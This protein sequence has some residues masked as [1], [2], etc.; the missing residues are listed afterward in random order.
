MNMADASQIVVRDY[1]P[2]RE[3]GVVALVCRYYR[4]REAAQ[5][6]HFRRFFDHPFQENE[7]LRFVALEGDRVVG[8]MTYFFWPYEYRGSRLRSFQTGN[9]LVDDSCR[10]KG[11]F[12]RLLCRFDEVRQQRGI[13]LIVGFPVE[14]SRP[15][16][17]GAGWKVVADLAWYVRIVSPLSVVLSAGPDRVY[18]SLDR[19]PRPIE[20]APR[21]DSVVLSRDADFLAWRRGVAKGD[22]YA[23]FHHEDSGHRLRLDLRLKRRRVRVFGTG[24]T[25][26]AREMM[27][28]GVHSSSRDPAFVEAGLNRL[29]TTMRR[30]RIAALLSIALNEQSN[31]T[32]VLEGV[33]RSGFRRIKKTYCFM[34]R[35]YADEDELARPE[36]WNVFRGDADTW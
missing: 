29:A 26:P 31:E 3:D 6:E 9:V 7:C 5:K 1:E 23:Y 28:G 21:P 30:N 11:V 32:F 17:Q 19:E 15:G 13:D 18:E 10:R 16:L 12:R 14:A 36:L 4:R 27:V 35:F 8:H 20:E 22:L 24:R 34:V 33:R 2:S 25:S